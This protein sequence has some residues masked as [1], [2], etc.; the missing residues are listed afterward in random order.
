MTSDL[1][2]EIT[3]TREHLGETVDA[4]AAKLDVKSRAKEADK[5]PLIAAGVLVVGVVVAKLL[6]P[7]KD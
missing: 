6:W 5:R 2:R 3:E 4:L 1:E 7:G